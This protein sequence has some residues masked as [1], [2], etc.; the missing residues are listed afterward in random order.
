MN[1]VIRTERE[2]CCDDVAVEVR[3]DALDY[4]RARLALMEERRLLP[5][6]ALAV[7]SRPLRDRVARLLGSEMPTRPVPAVVVL[8]LCLVTGGAALL[9]ARPALSET[10]TIIEERFYPGSA[11]GPAQAAELRGLRK[12]RAG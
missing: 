12:M 8:A 7:N 2:H 6:F 3:G 4:A 9:A 5:Q 10:L 11:S 1:R